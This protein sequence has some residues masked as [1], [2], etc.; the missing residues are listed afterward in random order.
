MTTRT[1]IC[2]A[3]T[4]LTLGIAGC[5][6]PQHAPPGVVIPSRTIT[7][8][9]LASRLGMRI[10][11][12]NDTF[13]VLKNSAN[14]VILFTHADGR[15]FVNGKPIGPSGAVNKADGIVQVPA[16]L[17]DQIRSHLLTAAPVKPPVKPGKTKG[18]VVI[19]AGHG[20]HDPGAL[21]PSGI[22]EKDINL[23]V[24]AKVANLLDQRGIGVVMTRWKDEYIEKEERAAIGNRRNA[25]LFVS[26]HADSAPSSSAQGF[27][28]YVAPSASAG[29]YR[30]AQAINQAMERTGMKNRGIRENDYRVLVKSEGPAVLIEMGYLSNAQ[31]V[32]RL[33]NDS[34]RDRLAEAI[35]DG[36]QAFLK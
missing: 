30:A 22:R 33:A 13:I 11:Q 19:D 36:I 4:C 31:D 24:A 29:A 25:D 28:I 21:S 3:I 18:L 14:T 8:E 34:F 15:F 10:E 6:G 2:I 32:A 26:I 9:Q 27:T 1:R 16:A 20:G 35:A 17:E 12:R 7:V 23:R 5:Q